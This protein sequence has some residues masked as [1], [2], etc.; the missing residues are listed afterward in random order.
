MDTKPEV[1]DIYHII[2]RALLNYTE[3]IGTPKFIFLSPQVN[4]RLIC[5][6]TLLNLW[7][8]EPA[9]LNHDKATM[10]GGE[11]KVRVDIGIKGFRISQFGYYKQRQFHKP[12][13]KVPND[14]SHRLIHQKSY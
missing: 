4:Y 13:I 10:L 1:D 12:L 11:V 2:F 9:L 5:E 6:C 8:F 3:F 7:F 14:E